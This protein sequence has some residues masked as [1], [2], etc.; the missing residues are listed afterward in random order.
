[1]GVAGWRVRTGWVGGG[2]VPGGG[3]Y[4][5]PGTGWLCYWTGLVLTGCVWLGGPGWR[6][7]LAPFKPQDPA[8]DTPSFRP[9]RV[10]IHGRG[11]PAKGVLRVPPVKSTK[12]ILVFAIP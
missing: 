12:S 4:L 11:G 7:G 10:E 1:M 6:S 3:R 9:A 2:H 8:I 5:L